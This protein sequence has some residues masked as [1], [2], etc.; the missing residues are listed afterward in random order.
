MKNDIYEYFFQSKN[1]TEHDLK[2]PDEV[3]AILEKYKDGEENASYNLIKIMLPYL[4]KYYHII[5]YGV[6]NTKDKDTL[7][8]VK[9]F[10]TNEATH[11]KIKRRKFDYQVIR[12]IDQAFNT[13]RWDYQTLEDTDIIQELIASLLE[14][15][16]RYKKKYK[17]VNFCG[18][19]YNAYRYQLYLNLKASTADASNNANNISY[20]DIENIEGLI[21]SDEP[22]DP[23]Q[24]IDIETVCCFQD[25]NELDDD[26]CKGI[27]CD[28]AF[29]DLTP[30]ERL[31]IKLHYSDK[32]SY[33]AIAQRTGFERRTIKNFCTRGI[34]KIKEHLHETEL[35]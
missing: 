9:L 27:T 5:R 32:E 11:A 20:N 2:D 19:I 4:N 7:L 22:V 12:D 33:T 17:H 21:D 1:I 3:E 30:L 34:A 14:L 10:I 28:I 29:E 15:A 6:G 25:H 13:I 16:Q 8:F 24:L 35:Y 23:N 18:Y 31:F 26:W